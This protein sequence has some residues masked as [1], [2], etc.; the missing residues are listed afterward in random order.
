MCKEINRKEEEE[1]I[2]LLL[3]NKLLIFFNA[4]LQ[5]A[6]MSAIR[7]FIE[8]KDRLDFL[9]RCEPHGNSPEDLIAEYMVLK[10]A[11][12]YFLPEFTGDVAKKNGIVDEMETLDLEVQKYIIDNSVL[13]KEL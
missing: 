3:Q 7:N 8:E 11:I 5:D 1:K 9:I 4:V 13:R 12:L 2:L 6:P 10:E